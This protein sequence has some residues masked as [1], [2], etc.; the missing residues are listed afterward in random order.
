MNLP[1]IRSRL[2][3]SSPRNPKHCRRD[4]DNRTVRLPV[5][6]LEPGPCAIGI[7]IHFGS[8]YD[9]L[10]PH[11]SGTDRAYWFPELANDTVRELT[12]CMAHGA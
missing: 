6:Y 9:L 4:R 3:D 7:K 5:G 1:R 11:E 2:Q 10:L 8:A 12:P